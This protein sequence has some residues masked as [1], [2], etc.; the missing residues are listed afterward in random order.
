M[1]C[2]FQNDSVISHLRSLRMVYYLSNFSLLSLLRSC[3]IDIKNRKIQNVVHIH[4]CK[5][6]SITLANWQNTNILYIYK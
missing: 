3:G 2:F 6:F 4:N 5:V 1:A